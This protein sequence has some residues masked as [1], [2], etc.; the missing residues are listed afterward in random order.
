MAFLFRN[1]RL[2]I[3]QKV[4][5]GFIL[6]II[7]VL[8][9]GVVAYR[10]L[11]RI[12]QKLNFVVIGRELHDDLLEVRRYE[13]NY[14]LYKG[15]ENYEQ[16]MANLEKAKKTSQAI[17]SD[18]KGLEGAPYLAKLQGAIEDYSKALKELLFLSEDKSPNRLQMAEIERKLRETGKDLVDLSLKLAE[19][20]HSR[21]K[22]ILQILKR[23]LGYLSLIFVIL[24]VFL[25]ILVTRK[26]VK[27][28]S[29]IEKTTNRIAQGDFKPL[30]VVMTN[31]ETQAVVEAFNRMITE[32]EKRQEQL[33]QAQKL[34][35]LGILTSGIAHQLNNPLNNISTSCQI[36]ME[37]IHGGDKAHINKLL[38]NIDQEV[39]RSRDIVKGLLDF[40]REREFQ[41]NWINLENLV[42]RTIQLVS[43][44]LPPGVEITCDIPEDLDIYLDVQKFQE[45]LLNLVLNSI[46]AMP[47]GV[48]L[49][50]IDAKENHHN[51]EI[52]IKDNGFGIPS[53]Q[54]PY[55]FDPF[56]S[57][58][59]VGYGTGL[60]LS[61][62]HGIV[63]RHG[64]T[65]TVKSS[66]G[67]GTGFTI[68][69]PL[70]NETHPQEGGV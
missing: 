43:S 47:E 57:T 19:F 63:E 14:L 25:T 52:T 51:M 24:G 27:P 70:G 1:I 31:D 68:N 41:L 34:S 8:I 23:D 13:K 35:S 58:K 4:V 60:G 16:A 42:L 5:M 44:Q 33:V 45:V 29:I 67:E 66:V 10:N 36:L 65:I 48:G 55:I 15:R 38:A 2:S 28:L 17:Q 53:E 59:E 20:E 26:I 40:S 3:R 49:I 12:E 50:T 9:L 54:L 30:P 46:Q 69:L 32:L 6:S 11:L 62:A 22:Q 39:D 61:V 37:E 64:G 56:F 21:I 18:F 7:G